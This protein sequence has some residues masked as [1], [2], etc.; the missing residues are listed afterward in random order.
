MLHPEI[1][2]SPFGKGPDT[3]AKHALL[4]WTLSPTPWAGGFKI[5]AAAVVELLSYAAC[6]Q[7]AFSMYPIRG[8]AKGVF[9]GFLF[10]DIRAS[11]IRH[12]YP[13]ACQHGWR[14]T[15]WRCLASLLLRAD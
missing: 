14:G 8:L 7:R 6:A 3:Y 4:T 12:P 9:G 5:E 15:K 10:E 2:I 13:S 1:I 11:D